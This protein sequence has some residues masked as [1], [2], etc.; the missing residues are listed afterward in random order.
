M[1]MMSFWMQVSNYVVESVVSVDN[2]KKL[3]LHVWYVAA[4]NSGHFECDVNS[5][6][7]QKEN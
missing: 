6:E 5:C 3:A 2:V 4:M 7:I 1:K